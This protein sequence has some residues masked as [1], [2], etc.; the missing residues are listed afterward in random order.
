MAASL[1]AFLIVPNPFDRLPAP[2]ELA[3][4]LRWPLTLGAAILAIGFSSVS[5]M[6][7]ARDQAD[8]S[9]ATRSTSSPAALRSMPPVV[10]ISLPVAATTAPVHVAEVDATPTMP[11]AENVTP[12]PVVDTG[13]RMM[14]TLGLAVRA[15][16]MTA[17]AQ[18]GA[19]SQGEIVSIEGEDRGWFQVTT[20]DGR[21]GWSWGRYLKPVSPQIAADSPFWSGADQDVAF[22]Q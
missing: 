1:P 17:S 13:P 9:L 3:G 7:V 18:I 22:T 20:S 2:R 5:L 8:L 16:P 6:N 12:A 15:R 14:A 21:T 19:L 4:L 10:Q 11:L